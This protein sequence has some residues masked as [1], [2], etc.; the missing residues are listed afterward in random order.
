MAISLDANTGIRWVL[1]NAT[2]D[3]VLPFPDGGAANLN[4]LNETTGWSAGFWCR[5]TDAGTLG[6]GRGIF[7]ISAVDAATGLVLSNRLFEVI[8]NPAASQW[9]RFRLV[10]TTADRQANLTTSMT[11]AAFPLNEWCFIGISYDRNQQINNSTGVNTG[12]NGGFGTRGYI[13][14]CSESY[15][16]MGAAD[17]SGWTSS[18]SAGT[19]LVDPRS[20]ADRVDLWIGQ[21]PGVSA[22][23]PVCV[24]Q[25][26]FIRKGVLGRVELQAAYDSKNP[27]YAWSTWG[28]Q[29]DDTLY[30][31][32][33]GGNRKVNND[34]SFLGIYDAASA[35]SFKLY[36]KDPLGSVSGCG[37][38]DSS[39]R[40]TKTGAFTNARRGD[41]LTGIVGTGVSTTSTIVTDKISDDAIEVADDING[42]GGDISDASVGFTSSRSLGNV[43]VPVFSGN[44][45]VLYDPYTVGTS[46]F[47]TPQTLTI[48]DTSF[49]ESVS[50]RGEVVRDWARGE[51]KG[52]RIV[53]CCHDRSRIVRGDKNNVASGSSL[54]EDYTDAGAVAE[55]FSNTVG[56]VTYTRTSATETERFASGG[57]YTSG[58]VS[59]DSLTENTSRFG[60]LAGNSSSDGGGRAVIISDA[61]ASSLCMWFFSYLGGM[62]GL[63]DT[64][65]VT[66]QILRYPQM[67][68]ITYQGASSGDGGSNAGTLRGSSETI[69]A[70]STVYLIDNPSE[71]SSATNNTLTLV[72]TSLGITPGMCSVHGTGTN[73]YINV[74]SSVSEGGG[75]TTLTYERN[76][77]VNPTATDI[78]AFG[79]WELATIERTFSHFDPYKGLRISTSGTGQRPGL[80]YLCGIY[81]HRAGQVVAHFGT[82]GQTTQNMRNNNFQ[83][84]ADTGTSASDQVNIRI[85]NYIRS[86][87]NDA[88]I[89]CHWNGEG[90]ASGLNT[91]LLPWL[92]DVILPTFGAGRV[93][94]CFDKSFGSLPTGD[95]EEDVDVTAAA[96]CRS[97]N[98]PFVT[99]KKAFGNTSYQF[100]RIMANDDDHNSAHGS[101]LAMQVWKRGGHGA[102]SGMGGLANVAL[103]FGGWR[104]RDWRNWRSSR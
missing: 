43:C 60:T 85:L 11:P 20:A 62:N 34:S 94:V 12:S 49:V 30:L 80:V 61:S 63:T 104:V 24:I 8:V 19:A 78:I 67:A 73:V 9:L 22:S 88:I 5:I 7:G 91:N 92:R 93:A 48:S 65:T 18:N 75:N 29:G 87:G 35:S 66:A 74:I 86:H 82:G 33:C 39:K 99:V 102:A 1:D 72:G 77:D 98:I 69:S 32:T 50:G 46:G 95:A 26:L 81:A 3:G 84:H 42:A 23:S 56:Y 101:N 44:P 52:R 83:Y 13:Y 41:V 79:K 59:A 28:P 15:P 90:N 45:P 14:F 40:I 38:T 37:W 70:T 103:S 54:A 6:S 2:V 57:S 10:G 64:F 96:I 55:D 76:H 4:I 100:T 17:G 89:L 25:G 21:Q 51:Y 47:F 53:V 16:T 58:S 31:Y 36:A 68:S 97:L 71:F 27:L